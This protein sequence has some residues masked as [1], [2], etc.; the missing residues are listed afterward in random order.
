[1]I[2][3]SCYEG[4]LRS[5]RHSDPASGAI[6][7]SREAGVSRQN[8]RLQE[9]HSKTRH[10]AICCRTCRTT[11]AEAPYSRQICSI[12]LP[13]LDT[14][15]V[16]TTRLSLQSLSHAESSAMLGSI[17][18]DRHLWPSS[19]GSSSQS[20]SLRNHLSYRFHLPS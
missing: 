15:L 19:Y 5:K 16:A 2:S 14:A 9:V 6:V 1:M 8:L 4:F 11:D 17:C 20:S 10:H 13:S 18:Q 7:Q 3:V 12:S